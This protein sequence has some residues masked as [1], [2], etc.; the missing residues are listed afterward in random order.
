LLTDSR[1]HDLGEQRH[2][3]IRD[4]AIF[5]AML[6]RG[7]A[8]PVADELVDNRFRIFLRLF[9]LE[10]RLHRSDPRCRPGAWATG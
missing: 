10:Q 4:S 5:V 8:K 3:G 6:G 9:A 2:F 1:T 7:F